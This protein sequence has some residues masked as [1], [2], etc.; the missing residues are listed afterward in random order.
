MMGCM[1]SMEPSVT[2][3]GGL[4]A[5]ML[6]VQLARQHRQFGSA[7]AARNAGGEAAVEPQP[8]CLFAEMDRS[9]DRGGLG[10][11]GN[12]D[13]GAV[14]AAADRAGATPTMV[15]GW[16][17]TETVRPT[18]CGSHAE[19]V[20]PDLFGRSPPR[21]PVPRRR[22]RPGGRSGRRGDGQRRTPRRNCMRPAGP[23]TLVERSFSSV[24]V[25][26]SDGQAAEGTHAVAVDEIFVAVT[27]PTGAM[28]SPACSGET[29]T[30][31]PGSGT[32]GA[33]GNGV[34]QRE[35]ADVHADAERQSGDDGGG[36]AEVLA[37]EAHAVAEILEE[38]GGAEEGRGVA[39]VSTSGANPRT[40]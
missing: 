7:P 14:R 22:I 12:P 37:D 9:P 27:A 4:A 10:G 2:S 39:A 17:L 25:R 23:G 21:A 40:A 33:E 31:V 35:D 28:P 8:G 24:T 15:K 13:R 16:S 11:I 3:E 1:A 29:R 26:G 36:E 20:A 18:I 6:A 30:K 34:D 5:G 32:R 38:S 19:A